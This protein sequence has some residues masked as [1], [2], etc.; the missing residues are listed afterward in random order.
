M[1]KEGSSS[2]RRRVVEFIGG[3]TVSELAY[4]TAKVC[5]R[6]KLA[7]DEA[8]SFAIAGGAC[9]PQAFRNTYRRK[10]MQPQ[11]Q[12]A[13][14]VRRIRAL[15]LS[16]IPTQ[17]SQIA[18]PTFKRETPIFPVTASPKIVET[19]LKSYT[20][21]DVLVQGSVIL[22]IGKPGSGKSAFG[23][24]LL[25]IFQHRASCYVINLPKR[26][27]HL[28][29]PGIGVYPSLEDAPLDSVLLMD[30][31][32]AQFSSR[33]S[34]SEKNQKLL[35]IVRLARQ[36][37]QIIIFIC[38]EASYL[39]ITIL[40]GL[41][42]LIIKEP[43]PLQVLVDRP[44]LKE[45]IQ[46]AKGKFENVEEDKRTR[47]YIAFSPCGYEGMVV[48]EKPSFF[49]DELSRCYAISHQESEERKVPV[50]SKEEKKQK[51]YQWY[52]GGEMSIRQM[53]R[54]LGVSK[55]TAWNWIREKEKEVRQANEII[56]QFLSE[57]G[58]IGEN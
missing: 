11:P 56:S 15:D 17:P 9:L 28:L 58:H 10:K 24:F 4:I 47:A 21:F 49:T 40:R 27:H 35:E 51:A 42:T 45:F 16:R 32:A 41:S 53:A 52:L 54:R 5:S 31:A 43:A 2:N 29:P 12:I 8:L 46:K 39:D 33:M 36:R 37:N 1:K 22:V 19:N 3:A 44:E 26:V 30:E 55:S 13:D 20:W 57:F 23:Y 34:N 14:I 25:E 48:V 50:L 38:Q 18:T 7:L 6:E